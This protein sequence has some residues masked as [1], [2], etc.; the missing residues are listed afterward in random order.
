MIVILSPHPDDAVLSLWHVLTGPGDVTVLTVFGGGPAHASGGGWW[1]RLTG[2]SDPA[3]R[4]AEREAEDRAALA[5]AGR[6]PVSLGLPG[7]QYGD[8]PALAPVIAQAAPAGTVLAPAGLDHH[9]SHV[10]VRDAA[11]AL[12]RDGREVVLYAD[13]PH[14]TAFGWPAWVTGASPD[15]YLSSEEM[16]E[17]AMAGTGLSL[18]GLAADVHHLDPEQLARKR[19]AVLAYRTQV[20][21]L[22]AEFRVLDDEVLGH[23][24]TWRVAP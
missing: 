11:L 24:V 21:A 9:P 7:A 5:L 23:E 22:Q 3:V 14:A 12:G 8:A 1:D 4:A 20:P 18:R 6:E 10:A 2:A 15:P 13:V 17:Q 19:D 16:W